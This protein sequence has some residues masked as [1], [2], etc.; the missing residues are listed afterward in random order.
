[1][2]RVCERYAVSVPPA[3]ASY[4]HGHHESVLRSHRW[5]TAHDDGWFAILHGEIV[6]RVA[7]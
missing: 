3:P 5:R 4:V 7:E 6:C 2:A 1:M